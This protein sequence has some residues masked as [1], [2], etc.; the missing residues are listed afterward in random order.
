MTLAEFERTLSKSKLPWT[1]ISICPR[2][3]ICHVSVRPVVSSTGG[4]QVEFTVPICGPKVVAM[5]P[6]C[7]GVRQRARVVGWVAAP[8][9]TVF[10]VTIHS[11]G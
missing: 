5:S 6:V 9:N 1:F 8:F 10:E 7:C 2:H 3:S 4:A 11:P